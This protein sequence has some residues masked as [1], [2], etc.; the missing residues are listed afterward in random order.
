MDKKN[1][2]I[3]TSG[4]DAPGMN[5]V[6]YTIFSLAQRN[7]L[8]TYVVI[9]GYEGLYNNDIRVA[10]EKIL[11]RNSNRSGSVIYSS[12]FKKMIE[13]DYIVFEMIKNLKNKNIQTLFILGGNGSFQGAKLLLKNG[14]DVICL[15]CTID[16]DIITTEYTIGFDSA[17]T[18]ICD[19][20]D[21]LNNTANS[22]GNV[23]LLEI[24]GREC[25]DLTI[26]ASY[27]SKVDYVVTPDNILSLDDFINIIQTYKKLKKRS[28]IFLI[29][30]RIYGENGLPSLSELHKEI[31]NRTNISTK[32]HVIGFVQRGAKPTALERYNATRLGIY[33]FNQFFNGRVNICVG[34]KGE[35]LI[36]HNL[37]DFKNFNKKTKK[38]K[39]IE[40]INLINNIKPII[41]K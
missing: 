27:A 4:G 26:A 39:T 21:N 23:F 24:M 30:E 17:L 28:I 33:A 2:A 20:I 32:T 9:G 8:Q 7:C 13:H 29:T 1:I 34:I 41:C 31:E 11:Y 6:L 36:S 12:R 5:K 19:T 37:L 25:S 35:N 14:I 15:P 16:N 40:K 38:S 3:L 10:N 22:H 18:A